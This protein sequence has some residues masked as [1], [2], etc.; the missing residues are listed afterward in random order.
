ME[1]DVPTD[2]PAPNPLS[3]RLQGYRVSTSHK[4]PTVQS[5]VSVLMNVR[6]Q[7]KPHRSPFFRFLIRETAPIDPASGLLP[8]TQCLGMQ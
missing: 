2:K 5:V 3:S 7:F 4:S 6:C 1:S 8:V